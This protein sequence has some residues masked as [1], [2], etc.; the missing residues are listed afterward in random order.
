MFS[1]YIIFICIV[2]IDEKEKYDPTNFRDQIV[3][4]LNE[5]NSDL[6]L[7]RKQNF[8]LGVLVVFS[9]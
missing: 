9:F 8:A 3:A 6:D 2:F 5:A 1:A 4:G 7:V